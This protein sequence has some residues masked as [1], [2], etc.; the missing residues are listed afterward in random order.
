MSSRPFFCFCNPEATLSRAQ[1][2]DQFIEATS[3]LRCSHHSAEAKGARCVH[4][5]TEILLDLPQY[6]NPTDGF[7]HTVHYV[8]PHQTSDSQ[9]CHIEGRD[10]C[11]YNCDLLEGGCKTHEYA[12]HY[13]GLLIERYRSGDIQGP[14][15]CELE[16]RWC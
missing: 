1:A 14:P 6:L 7:S 5:S 11:A 2:T 8:R 13:I 15:F 4:L 12:R 9:R 10:L 16:G 3:R